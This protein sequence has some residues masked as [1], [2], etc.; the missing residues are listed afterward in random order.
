MP[1]D[2]LSSLTRLE[3]NLRKKLSPRTR[4][5]RR[6][7][8]LLVLA[9]I[10]ALAAYVGAAR[11][12]LSGPRLRALI[13]TDP[14]SFTLDY[15][16]ATSFWPGRVTI[17]NLRHPRQRPERP[18]DHPAG[19]GA[20]RLFGS[21]A[22]E[23]DI[24]SRAP[25]RNGPVVL[26]PQQARAGEAKNADLSVLPPIPGFADPPL[27]SP[28]AQG[29]EAAGNPWRI[30]VRESGS[31]TSTTSGSTPATTAGPRASKGH[32]SCGRASWSGSVPRVFPSRAARCSIG[33]A[34]VGVSIS[35][36]IEGAFEPFEPP[37]VHGS[38]VWQKISGEVKLDAR[39][40]RLE[41][42]E[43][44]F[45]SGGARLE[46]GAGKANDPGA[47]RAGNREGRG[48]TRA[49]RR[50]GAPGETRA[51][52]RRRPAPAHSR[53][54]SHDRAPR[55]LG[56]PGRFLERP[57]LRLGRFAALVGPVRH[58]VGEDRLDH[59]H[60]H[61][62]RDTRCAAAA[63]AAGGRPPGLDSGS[64]GPRR[65]LRDGHRRLSAARSLAS[66]NSTPRAATITSRVTTS[67]TRRPGTVPS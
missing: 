29:P 52:R 66:N 36:S 31:T 53:V 19:R 5:P 45:S 40:D 32:S 51:S 35:G 7:L 58:T 49:S 39:F 6:L 67:A 48:P 13:N 54:E 34:P 63:R 55:D 28:A 65:L 33:R 20:R 10:L 27:R 57:R 4:H 47:H 60:A 16:E 43:H 21:L 56:Q 12:L 2:L 42:L 14:E 38:E 61:R 17:R 8:V 24:S 59:D 62:R 23:E 18:V 9:P 41:S 46:E 22:R 44:L 25:P 11:W 50:V 37:K 15:D 26:P 64:R 1:F 30:D 3:G